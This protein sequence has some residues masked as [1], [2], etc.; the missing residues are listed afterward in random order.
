MAHTEA[1]S[2]IQR[3]IDTTGVHAGREDFRQ[4]GVHAPPL[5][6]STTYPIGELI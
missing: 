1:N 4:L 6:L 2:M 3:S 5:D